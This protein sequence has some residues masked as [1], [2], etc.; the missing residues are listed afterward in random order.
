VSFI[1]RTIAKRYGAPDIIRERPIAAAEPVIGRGSD[2]DIQLTDLAVSLRH[3]ALRMSG[4]NRVIAEALGPEHFEANGKFVSRAELIVSA[5][6]SI[7]FGHHVLTLSDK[8]GDI[9]VTVTAREDTAAAVTASE[10]KAAFS[11]KSALFSQ[12]RT[13][14]LTALAILLACL[15]FPVGQFLIDHHRHPAM[16]ADVEKQ[17]SSGPLSPGHHFLEKDCGACHEKAFVPVK[18]SA[19]LSCHQADLSKP[20]AA[21]L[22]AM[23]REKGSPFAPEPAGDHAPADRLWQAMPPDPNTAKRIKQWVANRF[24]HPTTRCASCHTEHVGTGAGESGRKQPAPVT[25]AELTRNDCK[26]CHTGLKDRLPDTAIGDAPD[27]GH[28]P[29]FRPLVNVAFAPAGKPRLEQL[30][31]AGRPQQA[32][33]LIFSHREHLLANG[34]VAR[35][36]I[37]LGSGGGYG[38]ALACE[39]CHRPTADNKSFKPIEMTRDCSACHALD[40]ATRNGVPQTLKHGD[41]AAVVAQLKAYYMQGGDAADNAMRPP[42]FDSLHSAAGQMVTAQVRR[43]FAT[44]GSCDGCHVI[45]RPASPDSLDFKVAPVNLVERHL[46]HGAFDHDIPAHHQDASGKATCSDCHAAEKSDRTQDV[47]LPHINECDDCHGKT[48]EQAAQAASSDCAECH[49]FHD[50]GHPGV[51]LAAKD[52]IKP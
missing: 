20:A 13:A 16:T 35:M 31:L 46:P 11:L 48:R 27:W 38:K 37:D 12:R 2:C 33:G 43:A 26:D 17:W 21:H 34:R 49:D 28:H 25:P 36:A 52:I 6:P 51:I 30:A 42:V 18:D 14:W 29:D 5:A 19:C 3:A 39:S 7:A 23:M 4:P 41:V 8:D 22:A 47:L 10:Q 45:T 40:F 32:T 50:T 44:G 9:T 15:V 1:L 24:G